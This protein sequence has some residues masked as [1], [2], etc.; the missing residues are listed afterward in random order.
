MQSCFKFAAKKKT[1]TTHLEK[2]CDDED[3]LLVKEPYF[4]IVASPS[5]GFRVDLI[6]DLIWFDKPDGLVP[7]S[8][9]SRVLDGEKTDDRWKVNA[10]S[11]TKDFDNSDAIQCWM[12]CPP[13]NST[14]CD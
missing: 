4:K 6:G 14:A 2:I 8:W 5:Y 1:T 9:I 12:I 13:P 7:R 11:A 10:D 3:I